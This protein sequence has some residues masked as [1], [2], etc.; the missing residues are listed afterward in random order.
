MKFWIEKSELTG[1][2]GD[3]FLKSDREHC[4]LKESVEYLL[5]SEIFIKSNPHLIGIYQKALEMMKSGKTGP[6]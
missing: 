5:N 6:V 4:H 3:L 2:K 1:C